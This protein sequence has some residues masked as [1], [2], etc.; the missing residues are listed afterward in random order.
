[1]FGGIARRYD[2]LN[3]LLSANLDR[4]WR[5]RAAER[6]AGL[7]LSRVLDLCGG[8]GDLTIELARHTRAHTIVCAD[9]CHPMLELARPKLARLPR[10]ERIVLVEADALRLPFA[11]H[12]FDAVTV[13]FGVRNLADV[14]RGLGEMRRVLRPGGHLVV[15]EFSRPEGA[16]VS[17]LYGLY[18]RRVLPRLGGGLAGRGG[19]A[20]RYLAETIGAFPAAEALAG[21]IR[22]SGFEDG[23]VRSFAAGIVA[24]H[25]ARRA[26]ERGAAASAPP[27]S[28][29]VTLPR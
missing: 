10:P 13:A 28:S 8:T 17:P 25:H 26:S 19:R 21:V 1:M 12:A 20:Y 11:E 2:V 22:Q 16:L 7:S 4:R 18:L 9:F 3:H 5:R 29:P 24:L 6:L 15:L 14:E 27:V 23:E